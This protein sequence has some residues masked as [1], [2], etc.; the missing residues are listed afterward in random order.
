MN[1]DSDRTQ[2]ARMRACPSCGLANAVT[3]RFCTS[4][5]AAL[6]GSESEVEESSI[7]EPGTPGPGER[8]PESR[9]TLPIPGSGL[10]SRFE[11]VRAP[12]QASV[13]HIRSPGERTAYPFEEAFT[14][15]RESGDLT[16]QDDR[17]LSARHFAVRKVGS[18][19]V[20]SDLDSSNGTFIRLRKEVELRP[21]DE[22]L[23][24]GQVF[25]F[26]V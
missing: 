10:T 14:V 26:L 6:T 19:Y 8:A 3:N 24:G 2:V 20:L 17:F 23:I 11:S 9:P 13:E 4:C 5:G 22:I 15:G 1:N 18:R 7:E 25:R 12:K 21:G 16:I